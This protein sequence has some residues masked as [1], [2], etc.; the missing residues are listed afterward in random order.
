[1]ADMEKKRFLGWE[2]Y[3]VTLGSI[4][5]IIVPE[6][7]GRIMQL[8]FNGMPLFYIEPALAGKKIKEIQHL[9]PKELKA[10]YGFL[11]YGGDK[12]WL[13]PQQDWIDAIPFFDLDAGP[14][15]VL[16]SDITQHRAHF[17]LKSQVC[18]ETRIQIFR[19]IQFECSTD[20][21]RISINR[22][23]LNKGSQSIAKGLWEVVQLIRPC[24]VL[25]PRHP[26]SKFVDGIKVYPEE[27]V[28]THAIHTHV[29]QKHDYN[30]V[31]C[32]D[33]IEFKFGSDSP[34]GWIL[35]SRKNPKTQKNCIFIQKLQTPLNDA[36]QFP[37]D[38]VIVEVYNSMKW[39]YL[40]VEIHSP[41][42]KLN[43]KEEASHTIEWNLLEQE[44]LD[45]ILPML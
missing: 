24:E 43:P 36:D 15:E 37:H 42:M 19:E 44:S 9:T 18:R 21:A 29:E 32:H 17:I 12:T 2:A 8:V 4:T 20:Q 34:K 13:A 39:N 35:A 31:L 41:L 1:M 23:I 3:E 22:R 16:H 26:S 14:Y 25:L 38:D 5:M 28:S 10:K 40:E 30:L 11:L 27:G 7:G 6:V 33:P 45:E